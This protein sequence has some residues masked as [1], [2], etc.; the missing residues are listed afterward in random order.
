MNA[1]RAPAGS[2]GVYRGVLGGRLAAD[3]PPAARPAQLSGRHL[4][5]ARLGDQRRPPLCPARRR[6]AGRGGAD[7]RRTVARRRRGGRTRHRRDPEPDAR[8]DAAPAGREPVR[9]PR[10]RRS[11][12]GLRPAACRFA[13]VGSATPRPPPSAG[14]AKSGRLPGADAGDELGDLARSFG[15]LLGRVRD[16]NL[17]LQGLAAAW[18]TNS[19]LLWP[20][21]AARS[22][23]WRPRAPRGA[24][25]GA[26]PRRY[27]PHEYAG[28]R[29][30]GRAADRA[31]RCGRRA[32]ALR[33]RGATGRDGRGVPSGCTRSGH[34]SSSGRRIPACSMAPRTWSRNCWTSSWRTPSISRRPRRRSESRSSTPRRAGVSR[35]PTRAAGCRPARRAVVRLTGL[36]GAQTGA[37][38][39][40]GL[41]LFIVRLVA[42][43]HGGRAMAGNLPDGVA[44]SSSSSC[45]SPAARANRPWSTAD[46]P[47]WG[48]NGCAGRWRGYSRGWR[49]AVPRSS[50]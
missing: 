14:A 17:Y 6:A 25:A 39:H 19:G 2:S 30:V 1:T 46:A 50:P 29:T 47:L 21:C 20:S 41:G 48:P 45:R 42:E 16:H 12:A 44:S 43:H 3:P 40:L 24:L 34:S 10:R 22:T 5:L 27:R 35:W 33:P 11:A 8:A 37:D 32:R 23:T 36:R 31:R 49:S 13:S 38:S 4:E 9:E 7:R 18:R 26:R 15:R 28:Q